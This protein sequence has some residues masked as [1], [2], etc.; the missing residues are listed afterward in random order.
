MKGKRA[1]E[2]L[3]GLPRNFMRACLLLLIGE[4]PA[5]GYDLLDQIPHLGIPH[6][7][8]GGLYHALRAMEQD[9][10]VLS[11]WEHSSAGPPRR[12]YRLSEEGVE[13]LHAWAGALRE[14]HRGS[15]AWSAPRIPCGAQYDHYIAINALQTTQKYIII[16][17]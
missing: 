5:H 8:P 16:K 12:T 11:W 1:E 4:Q 13:W 6:V 15:L 17:L 14:S 2:P 10:M 9:G 7:D 3:A